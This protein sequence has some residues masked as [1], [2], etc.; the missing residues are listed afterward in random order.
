PGPFGLVI[1]DGAPG[2][3]LR[4]W[5][6]AG[7]NSSGPPAVDSN[8]LFFVNQ[9]ALVAQDL[10]SGVQK[11]SF[12]GDGQL[13]TQPIVLVTPAGEFVLIDSPAGNLYAV[14]AATGQLAWSGN[15]GTTI[16]NFPRLAPGQ[17]LLV[18][19]AG[20]ILTAYTG[21]T[22]PPS[23]TLTPADAVNTVGTFH[24]VTAS[25]STADGSSLSGSQVLF[26]V[27]GSVTTTGTCTTD[28]SGA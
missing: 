22:P 23:V 16:P 9:G 12:A 14:D 11:W 17:G 1:L 19:P 4:S 21:T 7:P 26:S 27:Q 8:A 25:V 6:P 18:A 15:L 24:T 2:T 20:N 13:F 3:P 5:F 10:A 28:P